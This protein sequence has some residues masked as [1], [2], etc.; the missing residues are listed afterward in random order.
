[1]QPPTISL[2]NELIRIGDASTYAVS[3]DRQ[4]IPIVV[5]RPA[6]KTKYDNDDGDNT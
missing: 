3:G 4:E 1:M 5:V 6:G 2:R